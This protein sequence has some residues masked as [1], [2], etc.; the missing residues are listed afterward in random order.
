MPLPAHLA[1]LWNRA[2]SGDNK[3]D[4]KRLL[5]GHS[6]LA[7]LPARSPENNLIS[8]Q[9]KKADAFLRSVSQQVLN[10]LRISSYNWIRPVDEQVQLQ[11]WQYAAE[12]P[13]N[14][15]AGNWQF[16]ALDVFKHRETPTGSFTTR[17]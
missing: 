1:A 17:T 12:V 7:E 2:L 15:N 4:I 11:V 5:E 8:E 3:I 9:R 16:P 13:H 14:P 6:R 10:I